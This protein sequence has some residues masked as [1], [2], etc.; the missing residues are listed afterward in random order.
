VLRIRFR[1]ARATILLVFPASMAC[2]SC[3]SCYRSDHRGGDRGQSILHVII[4]IKLPN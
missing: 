2:R 4:I 1:A 3:S